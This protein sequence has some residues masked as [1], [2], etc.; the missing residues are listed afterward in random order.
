MSQANTQMTGVARLGI[1]LALV[2]G[3]TIGGIAPAFADDWHGHD[4]WREHEWRE[5]EWR[6]HHRPVYV[7]PP[8]IVAPPPR[9]YYVAPPAVVVPAPGINIVLPINIR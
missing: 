2:L 7:P 1:G 5:H 3:V 9:A 6:E 4:H 8:V